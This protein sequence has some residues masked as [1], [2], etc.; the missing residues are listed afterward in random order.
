M[1]RFFGRMCFPRYMYVKYTHLYLYRKFPSISSSS[2][3][4]CVR[5]LG[6]SMNNFTLILAAAWFKVFSPLFPKLRESKNRACSVLTQVTRSHSIIFGSK[7]WK[8]S[9]TTP[10]APIPVCVCVCVSQWV[11]YS[12]IQNRLLRNEISY[13][14]YSSIMCVHRDI[15]TQRKV[16]TIWTVLTVDYRLKSVGPSMQQ[17]SKL[18]KHVIIMQIMPTVFSLAF[19]FFQVFS[20]RVR[21]WFFSTIS[22]AFHSFFK[23]TP[24]LLY[25]VFLP[26]HYHTSRFT[27]RASFFSRI[28]GLAKKG[29]QGKSG[30]SRRRP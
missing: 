2:K 3:N 29:K 26:G 8:R 18:S 1:Y 30:L 15:K 7:C 6:K 24:F 14:S 27:K 5:F 20:S 22:H 17:R 10:W 4:T 9:R 19:S 25:V 11:F 12:Y 21:Q 23:A 28:S 16:F 13:I